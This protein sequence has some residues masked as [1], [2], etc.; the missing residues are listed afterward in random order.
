MTELEHGSVQNFDNGNVQS[1]PEPAPQAPVQEERVFKQ[2]EVNDLIGR[3]KSEAVERFKRESSIASHQTNQQQQPSSQNTY[4]S[5]QEEMVRR[6]AGEEA[7]KLRNQWIEEANTR[8]QQQE[9]EKVANEFIQKIDSGKSK[10]QDYD[11]VM[12]DVNYGD[13]PD[14]VQVANMMENT[15]DIM[16]EL[17]KNPSKIGIIRQLLNISPSLAMA[18]MK[19]LSQSIKDNEEAKNFRHPNEPLSQLRPSHQGMDNKGAQTVSD[20]R[21]RYRNI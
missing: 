17:G 10:Y 1:S 7:Q 6:L 3:A 11:S 15:S 5:S 4:G 21:Q 19:R 20:Y 8:H 9:A 13:I 12:K 2:T 18:E 16:Y 14:I